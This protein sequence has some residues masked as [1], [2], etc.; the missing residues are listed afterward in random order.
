MAYFVSRS[1]EEIETIIEDYGQ[2]E[3]PIIAA[4]NY[5]W[6]REGWLELNGKKL[7]PRLFPV[8]PWRGNKPATE[9]KNNGGQLYSDSPVELFQEER[10]L[11]QLKK[12]QAA[13]S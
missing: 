3:R 13:K 7:K 11:K 1:N 4:T 10:A 8:C 9:G 12:E 6:L 2:P 5:A